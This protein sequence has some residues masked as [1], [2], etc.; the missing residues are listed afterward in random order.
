MSVRLNLFI[1]KVQTIP[2]HVKQKI[3]ISIFRNSNFSFV[4]RPGFEP[5][6]TVP[7]TVVLPLYY[8]TILFRNC[9]PLP[10]SN[11]NV[12][13]K[14]EAAKINFKKNIEAPLCTSPG[15]ETYR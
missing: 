14:I 13:R 4:V 9:Y 5:R 8:R 12:R 6:Q 3:R 1:I 7:K 2:N 15:E 10:K 11:A